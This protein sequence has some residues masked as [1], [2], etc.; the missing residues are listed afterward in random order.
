MPISD[1][2]FTYKIQFWWLS[3]LSPTEKQSVQIFHSGFRPNCSI[4]TALVKLYY[5]LRASDNGLV[6]GSARLFNW[7]VSLG[8]G[9]FQT[10]WWRSLDLIQRVLTGFCRRSNDSRTASLHWLPIT[11]QMLLMTYSA[12]FHHA[13]SRMLTSP[14]H[15]KC[16]L[17]PQSAGL[18]KV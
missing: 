17:H 14:Y 15:S 6:S 4:E 5:G 2:P 13:G 10:Y 12:K 9:W 11:F 18:L 8:L 16:P 3:Y 7:S 1:I